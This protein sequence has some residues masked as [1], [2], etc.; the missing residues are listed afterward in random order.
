MFALVRQ[1]GQNE[2]RPRT[3]QMSLRLFQPSA[4]LDDPKCAGVPC[5]NGTSDDTPNDLSPCKTMAMIA[6]E[7]RLLAR[8]F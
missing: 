5:H 1:V 2:D 8:I 7:A 3:C 6:P 4:L